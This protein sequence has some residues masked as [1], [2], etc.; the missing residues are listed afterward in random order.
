MTPHLLKERRNGCAASLTRFSMSILAN[1]GPVSRVL[2]IV[3]K[4]CLADV[5]RDPHQNRP[6]KVVASAPN[7]AVLK[8]GDA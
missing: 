7:T 3:S 2:S 4:P 1:N 6:V 5:T 8:T